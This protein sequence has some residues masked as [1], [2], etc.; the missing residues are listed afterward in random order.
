MSKANLDINKK[1]N[2]LSILVLKTENKFISWRAH[3]LWKLHSMQC[4]VHTS[5]WGVALERLSSK[6]KMWII[7]IEFNHRQLHWRWVINFEKCCITGSYWTCKRSQSWRQGQLSEVA[8]FSEDGGNKPLRFED[9]Y[10]RD[11]D[12]F[13]K[14]S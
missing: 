8:S 9:L 2:H 10:T 1:S 14:N 6:L 4:T 7:E 12:A 11:K 5:T 3:Y 13:I